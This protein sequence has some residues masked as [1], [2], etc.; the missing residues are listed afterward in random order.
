[1]LMRRTE[2]PRGRTDARKLSHCSV[3]IASEKISWGGF[4]RSRNAAQKTGRK[5][6]PCALR[7]VCNWARIPGR[8]C[9]PQTETRFR[10]F[11]FFF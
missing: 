11:P 4:L 9:G 8:F 6:G 3:A 1:M 7:G 2:L 10:F 5:L